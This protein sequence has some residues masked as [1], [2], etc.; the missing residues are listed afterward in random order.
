MTDDTTRCSPAPAAGPTP[1]AA[2]PAEPPQPVEPSEAASRRPSARMSLPASSQP[3][4]SGWASPGCTLSDG[5]RG[6]GNGTAVQPV[7]G[8][9]GSGGQVLGIEGSGSG[10]GGLGLGRCGVRA[11]GFGSG[12]VERAAGLG[13]A[14]L[15]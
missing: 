1:G 8:T 6:S 3:P 11:A 10:S 12:R 13:S 4:R 2:G 15:W 5:L 9:D 14:G 7:V